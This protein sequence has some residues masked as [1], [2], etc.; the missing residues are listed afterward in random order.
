MHR[1]RD[2]GVGT[3]P[4]QRS[5]ILAPSHLTVVTASSFMVRQPSIDDVKADP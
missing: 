2:V 3:G 4:V 5:T 1:V